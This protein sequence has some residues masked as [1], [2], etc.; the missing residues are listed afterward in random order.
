LAFFSRSLLRDRNDP[1]SPRKHL[2]TLLL[3]QEPL[4]DGTPML[5]EDAQQRKRRTV[6]FNRN[7]G[8]MPSRGGGR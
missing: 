7:N 3:D 6:F 1:V 4:G 2:S 8:G 5:R